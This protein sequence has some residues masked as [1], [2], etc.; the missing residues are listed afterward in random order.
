MRLT[1]IAIQK[2]YDNLK[3]ENEALKRELIEVYES[4]EVLKESRDELLFIS[5]IMRNRLKDEFNQS[6]NLK[7]RAIERAEAQKE[8]ETK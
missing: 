6:T 5:K 8:K 7:D 1:I 3:A 4:K 2:L